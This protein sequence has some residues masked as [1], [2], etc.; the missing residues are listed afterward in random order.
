MSEKLFI[1]KLN[2]TTSCNCYQYDEAV[3]IAESE[4]QAKSFNTWNS[5]YDNIDCELLGEANTNL[6]C[7]LIVSNSLEWNF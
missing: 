3:V 1:Y 6:K 2:S 5:D 4:Q 7:G